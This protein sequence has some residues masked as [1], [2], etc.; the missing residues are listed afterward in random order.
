MP[1]KFNYKTDFPALKQKDKA[2]LLQEVS[3][4]DIQNLLDTIFTR[5]DV[6]LEKVNVGEKA[7]DFSCY[8]ILGKGLGVFEPFRRRD[9]GAKISGRIYV[10]PN[11]TP[12]YTASV[13]V[14]WE[15]FGWSDLVYTRL[16]GERTWEKQKN[17]WW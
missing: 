1:R 4:K 14:T 13:S 8:P 16:Y 5:F 6:E 2:E 12:V 9:E 10:E 3:N 11:V 17:R 7:I 15:G